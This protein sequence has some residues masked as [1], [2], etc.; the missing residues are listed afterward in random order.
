MP[1]FVST[2]EFLLQLFQF[3]RFSFILI[4]RFISNSSRNFYIIC[5]LLQEHSLLHVVSHSSLQPVTAPHQ[6]FKVSTSP[7]PSDSCTDP[8]LFFIETTFIF[9]SA[10]L[11]ILQAQFFTAFCWS[12]FCQTQRKGTKSV[13]DQFSQSQ[14]SE[15]WA[16]HRWTIVIDEL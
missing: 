14:W 3:W 5:F 8:I 13:R 10:H 12:D 1:L 9:S 15:I 11:P 7:D 6:R 16:A 4:S 2:L